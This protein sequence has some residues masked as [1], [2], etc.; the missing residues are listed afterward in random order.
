MHT[1]MIVSLLFK[2]QAQSCWVFVISIGSL[3]LQLLLSTLVYIPDSTL[4]KHWYHCGKPGI[5]Q[6]MPHYVTF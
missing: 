4:H 5:V 3:S 6:Q 2:M 1:H